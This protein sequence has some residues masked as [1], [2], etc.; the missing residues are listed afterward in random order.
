MVVD[1]V[2]IACAVPAL[3]ELLQRVVPQETQD[4]SECCQQGRVSLQRGDLQLPG[5]GL[6][7]PAGLEG[8]VLQKTIRQG[9]L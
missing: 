6:L 8:V 1:H 9:V 3:E 5:T 2:W 4:Q 7:R